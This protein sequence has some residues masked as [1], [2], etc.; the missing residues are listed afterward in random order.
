MTG[1]T[2]RRIAAV[3]RLEEAIADYTEAVVARVALAEGV[4]Y[5]VG[6]RVCLPAWVWDPEVSGRHTWAVYGFPLRGTIYPPGVH[7]FGWHVVRRETIWEGTTLVVVLPPAAAQRPPN[8]LL[9]EALGAVGEQ[10]ACSTAD[11]ARHLCTRAT[12]LR[13]HLERLSRLGYLRREGDKWAPPERH[14]ILGRQIPPLVTLRAVPAQELLGQCQEAAWHLE[15]LTAE[16]LELMQPLIHHELR[17]MAARLTFTSHLFGMQDAVAVAQEIVWRTLND[18]AGPNRPNVS[19]GKSVRDRIKRDVPRRINAACG[20]STAE[21]MCRAWL[22]AHP[23]I[24]TPADAY[25][26]GLSRRISPGVVQRCLYRPHGA[27]VHPDAAPEDATPLWD[28]GAPM[29]PVE[30]V[31]WTVRDTVQRWGRA[32]GLRDAEVE[33]WM[34][35]HGILDGH[36]VPLGQIE[37]LW[38]VRDVLG[39]ERRLLSTF[40]QPGEDLERDESAIKTRA[41]R[42]LLGLDVG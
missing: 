35:Y 15:D 14:G 18:F 16:V 24:R 2:E 38:G 1:G 4:P 3:E 5:S 17:S 40:A 29:E 42:T 20:E 36:R 13:P 25:A 34:A 22:E 9:L 39:V 33:A 8:T 11:L 23:G 41:V 28:R 30:L 19:F 31:V 21:G 6:A 27:E 12:R 10:G 7:R 26:A 32:A 37:K